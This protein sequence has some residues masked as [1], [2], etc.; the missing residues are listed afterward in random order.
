MGKSKS[1]SSKGG[2]PGMFSKKGVGSSSS[3]STSHTSRPTSST[4]Q[5]AS[6]STAKPAT[7]HAQPTQASSSATAPHMKAPSSHTNNTQ[8][9]HGQQATPHP[10]PTSGM[11]MG[12][13]SGGQSLLGNIATT[14]VGSMV[15]VTAAHALMG[16]FG[17]DKEKEVAPSENTQQQ[18]Q[19]QAPQQYQNQNQMSD[20]GPCKPQYDSLFKC[21]E[22][23]NNQITQCQWASDLFNQCK[24][25]SQSEKFM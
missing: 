20:F 13:P 17:G 19:L 9:P 6:H 16:A 10:T 23:N 14:A 5:Q 3:S 8:T 4:Q 24:Q 15:G 7:P 11:G 22:F 18:S 25:Q 1:S 21:I 2:S 12:A